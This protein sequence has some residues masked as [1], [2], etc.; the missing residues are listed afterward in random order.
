[1]RDSYH[2]SSS[3]KRLDCWGGQDNGRPGSE[4]N[5]ERLHP[6]TVRPHT[7]VVDG[8][9]SGRKA[10]RS[11]TTAAAP[12][13]SCPPQR[14]RAH[15]R[16]AVQ[17]LAARQRRTRPLGLSMD[18]PGPRAQHRHADRLAPRPPT[19]VPGTS[20]PGSSPQE[21]SGTGRSSGWPRRSARAPSPS[22]SFMSTSA[23]CLTRV[24]RPDSG[25][26]PTGRV[27]TP[28]LTLLT[29]AGDRYLRPCVRNGRCSRRGWPDD[30]IGPWRYDSWPE[31][32]HRN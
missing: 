21:T 17:R 31:C 5:R 1:M 30:N 11:A 6:V 24:T 32:C 20:I 9:G 12:P 3:P 26:A 2:P 27:D 25:T 16:R 22:S 14:Y 28:N 13:R 8:H 10:S 7:E 15:W 4:P 23:T 19:P 29:S 18:R